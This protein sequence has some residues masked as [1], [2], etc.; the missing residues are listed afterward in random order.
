MNVR[1]K[2]QVKFE[3]SW[4]SCAREARRASTC[5]IPSSG[6]FWLY[7]AFMNVKDEVESIK[8]AGDKA[9]EWCMSVRICT[10]RTG[11]WGHTG[12]CKHRFWFC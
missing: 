4:Q 12:I 10:Y 9:R 8:Y 5:I 7:L 6:W 2:L 11:N 3:L 1:E